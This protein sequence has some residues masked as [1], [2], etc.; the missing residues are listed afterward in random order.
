MD[1]EVVV[2][3]TDGERKMLPEADGLAAVTDRFGT[4]AEGEGSGA[5]I[6]IVELPVLAL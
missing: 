1:V 5:L 2:E 3:A 6:L 4:V